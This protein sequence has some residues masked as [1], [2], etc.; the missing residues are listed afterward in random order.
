M[1]VELLRSC[2]KATVR[3]K[4]NLQNVSFFFAQLS[5]RSRRIALANRD[6]NGTAQQF[7]IELLKVRVAGS[8]SARAG[9]NL[10]LPKRAV[11][12]YQ[13]VI[14]PYTDRENFPELSART[15]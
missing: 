12:M 8:L 1:D 13:F 10:R 7:Q 14:R 4:V 3:G 9:R 5:E 2:L 6:R 11:L 15:T